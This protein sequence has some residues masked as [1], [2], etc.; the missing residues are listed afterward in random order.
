MRPSAIAAVDLRVRPAEAAPDLVV[1][2]PLGLQQQR[3]RLVG[4]E[5]LQRLDRA[6]HALAARDRVLDL[7][8]RRP[9]AL[10][11]VDVLGVDRRLARALRI[12]IASCLTT[13][14]SHAPSVAG[15]TRAPAAAGRS[16][17]RAG[18]RPARRRGRARTGSRRAAAPA[19]AVPPSPRPSARSGHPGP[20]SPNAATA[21]RPPC[22]ALVADLGGSRTFFAPWPVGEFVRKLR[23]F[24]G[25][26]AERCRAR[27]NGRGVQVSDVIAGLRRDLE[28][29]LN[30]IERELAAHEPLRARARAD[31]GGAGAAAVRGA[32]A[33]RP[34]TQG[35]V[36]AQAAARARRAGR[37]ARRS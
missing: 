25:D 21:L 6:L 31:P 15:S 37:T 19:R 4:L 23:P 32:S 13:T 35:H 7:A 30:D 8:Q 9:C 1:G 5:R 24:R 17:A 28:Q 12:A 2:E 26:A 29:R 11:E 3:P 33:A 34:A 36:A 22:F 14:R 27:P 16:P 18:R 10:V 20:R